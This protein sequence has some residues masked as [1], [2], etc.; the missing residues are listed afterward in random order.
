MKEIILWLFARIGEFVSTGLTWK[1]YGDFSLFHF[2][3]ACLFLF[4]LFKLFGFSIGP[5]GDGIGFGI[6]SFKNS[7]NKKDKQNYYHVTEV[8][9]GK[10]VNRIY[11]Y[12]VDKRTG[13]AKRL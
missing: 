6:L 2:I 1:I 10:D 13:E 7:E 11:R 5:V 8:N 3:L 9:K 12:K 4:A